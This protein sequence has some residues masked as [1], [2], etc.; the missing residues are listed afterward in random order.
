MSFEDKLSR[1]LKESDD[2]LLDLKRNTESK[3]EA[4]APVEVTERRFLDKDPRSL[5]HEAVAGFKGLF[6]FDSPFFGF[7][8]MK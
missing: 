5:L 2:R 6:L 7:E 3:G 1:F 4:A 8:V